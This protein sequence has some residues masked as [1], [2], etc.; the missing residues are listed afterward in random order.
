MAGRRADARG[1]RL[2]QRW[3]D[4]AP[5]PHEVRRNA[6]LAQD[7]VHELSVRAPAVAKSAAYRPA[8]V[9]RARQPHNA[10]RR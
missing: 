2:R 10:V 7:V 4:S 5:R 9:V 3:R 1:R 8:R 6:E